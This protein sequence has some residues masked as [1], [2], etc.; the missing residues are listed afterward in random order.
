MF[1]IYLR[2]ASN[3]YLF[4]LAFIPIYYL[5][6]HLPSLTT[7][8]MP[9]Y[10]FSFPILPP[11]S[12]FTFSLPSYAYFTFLPPYSFFTN[13]PLFSTL[14]HFTI[15]TTHP[16]LSPPL[17]PP[18]T[19]HHSPY[20]LPTLPHLTLLPFL[21]LM[22]SPDPKGLRLRQ[23]IEGV[24]STHLEQKEQKDFE[25]SVAR[26]SSNPLGRHKLSTAEPSDL[27]NGENKV[28]HSHPVVKDV[29]S[30]V[31]ADE[32]SD[33]RIDVG[34]SVRTHTTRQIPSS[35][36]GPEP[37]PLIPQN[38]AAFNSVKSSAPLPSS[39]SSGFT[40][41]QE[42]NIPKKKII[43]T[44]VSTT[45]F[46]IFSDGDKDR[47]EKK[48]ENKRR[49][50]DNIEVYDDKKIAKNVTCNYNNNKK[51][52]KQKEKRSREE[53]DHQ[54]E[55]DCMLTELGILDS[56]DGTI[57]TRLARSEIASNLCIILSI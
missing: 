49:A 33:A 56:E 13:H 55:L 10:F 5:F 7:H 4:Y 28:Q 39:T 48:N 19:L 27:A 17:S 45:S 54:D 43:S 38:T 37:V 41:F 14:L 29:P 51:E 46:S 53:D 57:N 15:I 44:T 42:E 30:G 26:I 35:T 23:H 2:S 8:T 52:I 24:P 18:L 47:N 6:I 31:R 36:Q 50:N 22:N 25:L 20:S 16:F 32:R 21:P 9:F 40:I 1:F 34:I 11:S 12:L 3:Q